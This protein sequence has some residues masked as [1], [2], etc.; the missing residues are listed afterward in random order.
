MEKAGP[1]GSFEFV[2]KPQLV[3]SRM[4]SHE[5]IQKSLMIIVL[6]FYTIFLDYFFGNESFDPYQVY[7][8]KIYIPLRTFFFYANHKTK[9][10]HPS[11]V[12]TQACHGYGSYHSYV[13]LPNIL[14]LRYVSVRQLID[15]TL[16][17]G[18]TTCTYF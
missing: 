10:L 15:E 11:L 17:S 8:T 4:K 16:S 2:E 12:W 1:G 6:Q 9:L 13:L 5:V 18:S 14:D 3:G 7:T